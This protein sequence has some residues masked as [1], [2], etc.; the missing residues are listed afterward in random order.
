MKGEIWDIVNELDAI[1]HPITDGE[2]RKV[3]DICFDKLLKLAERLNK[4]Q[5]KEEYEK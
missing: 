3:A 4:E 2:A 5:K 1:N